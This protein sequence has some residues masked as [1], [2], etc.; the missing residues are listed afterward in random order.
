M[1]R[2]VWMLVVAVV[3]TVSVGLVSQEATG[4]HPD[5][6]WAF[7]S[8]IE[9]P[10]PEDDAPKTLP[11]SMRTYTMAQIDDLSNPPDWYPDQHPTPPPIVV[12]GHGGAMACGAC[13]L[14]SGLGHPESSDLTGL[15]A[16]Y[17]V[18]Q[19]ADFKSGARKDPTGKRMNGIAVEAT[20][21]DVRQAAQYI[22]ALPR[23]AFQKVTEADM[24][25]RTA[26]RNGRMR[27]LAEEGGTEPIGGRIITV[28]EDPARARLRDPNSGF[29]SYVPRGSLARGKA[30]VETGGGRTVMCTVCHGNDLKGLGK[31]PRL[32]GMHPIYTVRQLHWFKDGTRNGADAA[33]MKPVADPLTDEDIVAVSAYL[34]SLAP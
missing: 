13:H 16:E 25:P 12:K 2:V 31:V 11:G 26:L 33:Q 5:K 28:P 29:V 20:D 15:S 9:K 27:Y 7:P 24:A 22:A 10:F 4:L 18:Q 19:M 21:E 23:R 17:I 14:M 30:I 32:A 34:G 8:R 6:P 1:R 3:S